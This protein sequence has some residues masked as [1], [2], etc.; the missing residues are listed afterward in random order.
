MNTQPCQG[1]SGKLFG[2]NF[3]AQYDTESIPVTENKSELYKHPQLLSIIQTVTS[4][5]YTSDVG[6]NVASTLST[7][8]T[9]HE[10]S[11]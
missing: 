2:H 10:K 7:N 3:E 4:E 1:I 11:T 5:G 9:F 8:T 6:A